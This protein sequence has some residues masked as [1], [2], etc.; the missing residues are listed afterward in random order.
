MQEFSRAVTLSRAQ[1][2]LL[3][4]GFRGPRPGSNTLALLGLSDGTVTI[5]GEEIDR[6]L[7]AGFL[8]VR[9]V[10]GEVEIL[11]ASHGPFGE[12][13]EIEMTH[14]YELS[15]LGRRASGDDDTDPP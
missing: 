7:V 12:V 1:W 11:P 14:N 2:R 4:E 3:S 15:A 13:P 9:P 5:T 10:R 6:L 8:L